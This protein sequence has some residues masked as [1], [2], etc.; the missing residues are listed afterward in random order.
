M[1]DS[2]NINLRSTLERIHQLQI[3]LADLQSRLRRGPAVQK[4]QEQK[5]QKQREKLEEIQN[6]HKKLLTAARDKEQQV[7]ASDQN[8]TKRKQQLQEAKTNR[9]YQALQSQIQ[10]DEAARD[11]L[12]IDALEAMD[13]AEAFAKTISPVQEELKKLQ[14]IHEQTKKKFQ[15]EK[16]GIDEEIKKFTVL[17]QTEE[18][19]LPKSFSEVYT[20]L[21]RNNGGSEA[22]AVVVQQKFCGGCNHQIPINSLALIL[23]KKP[24]TCSSCARLLY[25]P[26]DFVFERG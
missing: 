20:R 8:I 12:E 18:V 13:K 26:E 3:R 24:I 10:I 6:E 19:K 25:L 11:N 4:S 16:P 15:E 7:T 1:S 21:V 22:L 23:Q 5:I 9:D 2:D 17:L 14:E